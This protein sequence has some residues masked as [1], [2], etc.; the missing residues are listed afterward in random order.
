MPKKSNPN[1]KLQNETSEYTYENLEEMDKCIEDEL[2]CIENYFK[3]EHPTR[4]VI[5]F[6]LYDFQRE[7]IRLMQ[8]HR[9]VI[10][11]FPRQCGKCCCIHASVD[12]L[13]PKTQ[14]E[15][16]INSRIMKK[17]NGVLLWILMKVQ[18]W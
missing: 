14:Y 4:G 3:I 17:I 18:Q 9:Y 7:A 5:P 12:V 10:L 11:L 1:I 15:N 6:E 13:E 8:Q 16:H 2:Y